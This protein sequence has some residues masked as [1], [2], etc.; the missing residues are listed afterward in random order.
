MMH[1]LGVLCVM[2]AM[3]ACGIGTIV[4]LWL[5]GHAVIDRLMINLRSRP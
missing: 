2:I 1:R 5:A 3:T 4:F